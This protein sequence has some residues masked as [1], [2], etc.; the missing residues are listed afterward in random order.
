MV[1]QLVHK[2]FSNQTLRIM[3]AACLIPA[4]VAVIWLGSPYFDIFIIAASFML[5]HEWSRMSLGT[6]TNPFPYLICFLTLGLIYLDFSAKK[7][8]QYMML[9]LGLFIIPHIAQK[10]TIKDFIFHI[11]GTLYISASV[12]LIIYFVHEGLTLYFLWIL[13]VVWASDSGAYFAGK[14]IG[15]PKLAPRVSPN[16][17]WSGFIGGIVASMIVGSCLGCYLQDLYI[18]WWQMAAVSFYL[19]LM[20]HLGDL[21]ESIVKRYFNVKDSGGILPGHGGLLDRLD[22]TLLASFAAGLLL[23]LGI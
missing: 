23:V 15:G 20:S 14:N 21:L 11:I 5:L 3:T 22:S 10:R 16:K 2:Q 9:S 17:T 12:Y 13:T 6:S 7:Y 4:V 8:L 1:Q 19:S 18:T